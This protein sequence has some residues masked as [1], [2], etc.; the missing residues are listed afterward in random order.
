MN[1]R[2]GVCNQRVDPEEEKAEEDCL[3]SRVEL[4]KSGHHNRTGGAPVAHGVDHKPHG[5]RPHRRGP[6]FNSGLRHFL[7]CFLET[8]RHIN[9][10]QSVKP[11][12]YELD[13]P[14][15]NT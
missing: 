11:L 3:T 8:L 13:L 10:L 6:R 4:V 9:S 1:T 12:L 15:T 5:L 14:L 2:S 7:H